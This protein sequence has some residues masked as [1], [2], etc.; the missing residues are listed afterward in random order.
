VTFNGRTFDVPLL[1]TR[2]LMNRQRLDLEEWLHFDLLHAAR[3]IWRPAV[4]SCALQSLERA[5]LRVG[6]EDDIE[7]FLIP[8]IYH[9]FL[10]DGDGRYLQRVFNHNRADILAMVALAA[11]ACGLMEAMWSGGGTAGGR[12]EDRRAGDEVRETDARAGYATA[13]TA[14][15]SSIDPAEC[16]GLARVFEQLEDWEAAERAY[17]TALGG[18][19]PVALRVRALMGLA[20]LLKRRRRHHDAAECWQLVTDSHPAHSVAALVEL[21]KYWEHQRRDPERAYD[22]ARRA[23][24]RW[25]AGLPAG[26][27]T[28]PGIATWRVAAVP[29]P[30]DD[31][32]RRLARLERKR[33]PRA[34]PSGPDTVSAA[35][36]AAAS[37][38]AVG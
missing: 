37:P 36:L 11:R 24:D 21:S 35:S 33:T 38:G 15:G 30:P 3:R 10:R 13:A 23:H 28:L 6:R 18:R 29:A 17:R 31:F 5:I 12:V 1:Q 26:G 9:Q 22:L 16:V 4:Q 25:R 32:A 2:F 19:L 34:R 7:S 20:A 8:A 27:R 14:H